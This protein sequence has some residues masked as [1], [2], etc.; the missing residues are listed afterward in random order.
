MRLADLHADTPSRMF[1]KQ[2]SFDDASLH[3]ALPHLSYLEGYTQFF[4]FFSDEDK[5]DSELYEDFF[6]MR[7]NFLVT[8]EKSKSD[9]P[10]NSRFFFTV[11]DAR[12]LAGKEERLD[13]LYDHGVR[14]LTPLWRGITHI[15]GAFDT[16]FPLTSFGKKA[17][18]RACRL[19]MLLDISHASLPSADDIL[20]ISASSGVPPLATHSNAYGVCPHPRNLCDRH[21]AAVRNAGG[22]IGISFAPQHLSTAATATVNDVLRHIDYYLANGCEHVLALGCDFDGIDATPR[23]LES[24]ACLPRL[25]KALRKHGVKENTIKNLCYRNAE[26]FIKEHLPSAPAFTNTCL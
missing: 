21:L 17:L 14:I 25:V 16:D 2:K 7:E 24:I 15:G 5:V 20:E 3:I 1:R 22:L 10:K 11:E 8:L 18:T 12:L 13:T 23:R 6:K 9:L 26:R 4:A 19:G